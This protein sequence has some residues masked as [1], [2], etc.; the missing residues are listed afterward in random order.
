MSSS[1]ENRK[2]ENRISIDAEKTIK[3]IVETSAIT[4][5]FFG[6]LL[7]FISMGRNWHY[8]FDFDT[9][10]LDI[11]NNNLFLL[12]YF[13]ICSIGGSLILLFCYKFFSLFE[14]FKKK[15]TLNEISSIIAAMILA[16]FISC[17]VGKVFNSKVVMWCTFIL[18]A[19][20]ET[21]SFLFIPLI[22]KTQ[23]S[24]QVVTFAVIVLLIISLAFS[25]YLFHKEYSDAKEEKTF[26]IVQINDNYYVI[27]NENSQEYSMYQCVLNNDEI[28][29]YDNKNIVI[30]KNN[31][32]YN[33]YYFDKVT[34]Q[35]IY[36]KYNS[37][38]TNYSEITELHQLDE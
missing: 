38:K 13:V 12:L 21:I 27:I 14:K 19:F 15:P 26:N 20:N 5:A 1:K 31:V 34:F 3:I 10:P 16:F 35:G 2:N 22:G 18:S 36:Y 17:V 23:K 29:I 25:G 28:I 4:T 24:S 37:K 33:T 30:E 32:V 9:F 7:K 6:M 11:S 8:Q